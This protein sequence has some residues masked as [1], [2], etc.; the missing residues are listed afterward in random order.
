MNQRISVPIDKAFSDPRLL[1]AA[2]GDLKSRTTWIAA[3][4]A[5][6]ALPLSKEELDI[7]SAI[8][9]GRALPS[10]RCR[11]LWVVAG[12]RS[13]KSQMSAGI[14]LHTALFIKHK[15]SPGEVGM[16]LILAASQA[17]A[18]TVFNYVKG[19]LDASPTLAR[20]VINAN[21][22]EITLKNGIVI[23][24]HS[25][26]FRTVRGRT[27]V[28]VVFDEVS[29]WRDEGSATPDVEVYTAVLPSLATQNGLLVGISTPYRKT[30]LLY[31]KHRDHWGVNG[32]VLVVQG[33]TR[34]FNPTLSEGTIETLS[35]ADPTAAASEWM[36]TFRNDIGAFLD[37]AT[38]DRSIEYGRPLEIPP[39]RPAF[40][41]AFC[42]ASGGVGKDS[43]TLSIAHKEGDNF[44]VDLIRGT[45]GAFDPQVVTEEYAAL[46]KEYRIGAIVGD[47]YGAEWVKSTW[48]RC[49]ITYT[50]SDLPK[51]AI[52]LEA[53]PLFTR[54]LVRLP[55]HPTLIRELRLLERRTHRGGKDSVD[56]PK[57]GH[58]DFANS[59]CG[60]LRQLSSRLG[61]YSL[62]AFQD[63]FVD[64]DAPQRTQAPT[65]SP[66]GLNDWQRQQ[67]NAYVM[68]R[69]LLRQ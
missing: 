21:Q 56:H 11:E 54:G 1:G 40:Y 64:R 25:N 63:D 29:F 26:S 2:L 47:H 24:V 23:G 36:A 53:M 49:N 48:S 52:Y 16:V 5:A 10:T 32:D 8:G 50:R 43:Y 38:I 51:S 34:T 7:F 58:D 28:A 13:G 12:R 27:L 17:Q 33:D 60:V 3:L 46:L 20:E 45:K 68:T 61:S 9:G 65:Q 14:G 15:L 35:A 62:D 57:N 66:Y 37:D 69:G 67:L 59:V 41:R 31:Q 22:N 39:M 44:V 19:F 6:Y 4:K 30:G 18:S 42:D 55:D